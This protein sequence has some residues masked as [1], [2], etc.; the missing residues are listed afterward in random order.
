M[1]AAATAA[2]ALPAAAPAPDPAPCPS[3]DSEAA[4]GVP[5]AAFVLSHGAIATHG[6]DAVGLFAQSLGGGGGTGGFSI[7]ANGAE[8]GS[9]CVSIGGIGATAA[10]D[11]W[12]TSPQQV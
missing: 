2:S 9:R 12:S 3:A 11:I 6:D 1:A 4:A 5:A 10:T 8:I 7:D